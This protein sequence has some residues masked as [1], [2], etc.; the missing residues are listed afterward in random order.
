MAF[1]IREKAFYPSPLTIAQ[2]IPPHQQILPEKQEENI[3]KRV[4]VQGQYRYPLTDDI[5]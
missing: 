3:I 4:N 2:T 5:V 1:T